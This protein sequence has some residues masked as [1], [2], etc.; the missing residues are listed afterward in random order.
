MRSLNSSSWSCP[1]Q[2]SS[3]EALCKNPF[4]LLGGC[5]LMLAQTGCPAFLAKQPFPLRTHPKNLQHFIDFI[6]IRPHDQISR[7]I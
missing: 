6:T 5:R 7:E 2:K 3:S 4:D 1:K